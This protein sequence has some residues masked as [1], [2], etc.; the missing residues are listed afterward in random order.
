MRDT[1]AKALDALLET[2]PEQEYRRVLLPDAVR[3]TELTT[4]ERADIAWITTESVDRFKEVV[5]AGGMDDSQYRLN[6][7][8]TLGHDYLQAPVGRSLWRRRAKEG[9]MRGIK[10]KTVYPPRP[11]GWPDP[12]WPA[13]AAFA[14][15]RSGLMSGKSIGFLTLEASAPT[16]DE[17]RQNAS[18]LGVRRVVRK[19]LL[20]EYACTW[21]PVNP[22]AVTEAV[23]K[24]QVTEDDFRNLRLELPRRPARIIPFTALDEVEKAVRRRFEQLSVRDLA[25]A[26]LVAAVEQRRG[27]V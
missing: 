14:L 13:D 27:R 12:V 2:L 9:D 3:A 6:P 8:V 17:V 25:R 23:S 18:W 24:S 10:A 5:L 22:D 4:G 1:D 19:W 20:L 16:E 26:A 11:D 21:L 15:V 7:I